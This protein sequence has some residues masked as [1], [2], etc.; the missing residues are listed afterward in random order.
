MLMGEGGW[1]V[2]FDRGISMFLMAAI[3][4]LLALPIARGLYRLRVARG[5]GIE[6]GR[7]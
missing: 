6:G 3:L 2:F 5:I 4:I 1:S 7:S